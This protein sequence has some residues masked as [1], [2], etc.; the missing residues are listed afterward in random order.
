MS[1]DGAKVRLLFA[2]SGSFQHQDLLVPASSL[3]GYDRLI[4]A[5]HEDPELMKRAYVDLERLCAAW[6]VTEED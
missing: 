6:L 2:D 5:F 3:R 1:D 4:D